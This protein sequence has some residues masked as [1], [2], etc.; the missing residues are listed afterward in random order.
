MYR[1]RSAL[2]EDLADRLA[3]Q[4]PGYVLQLD[5][6]ESDAGRFEALVEEREY[7]AQFPTWTL[8]EQP[9]IGDVALIE[10]QPLAGDDGTIS[11]ERLLHFY[12]WVGDRQ[13][14]LVPFTG[15]NWAPGSPEVASLID[16]MR[17]GAARLS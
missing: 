9:D 12:V 16:V 14:D 6:E 8:V 2:G 4:P 5:R 7:A 17:T 13:I 3:T 1:V 15:T 10:Y 11:G